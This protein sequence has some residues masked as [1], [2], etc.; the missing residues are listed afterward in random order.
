ML[1]RIHNVSF[2][3]ENSFVAKKRDNLMDHFMP[4]I[5]VTL[6]VTEGMHDSPIFLLFPVV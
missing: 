4:C 6:N 1:W 3:D 2:G 5:P